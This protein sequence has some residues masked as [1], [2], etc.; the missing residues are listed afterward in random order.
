MSDSVRDVRVQ[1]LKP[2]DSFGTMAE[3]KINIFF[4]NAEFY[5]VVHVYY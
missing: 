3:M 2:M 4:V 5:K 1:I